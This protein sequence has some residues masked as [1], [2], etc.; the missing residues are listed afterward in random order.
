MTVWIPITDRYPEEDQVVLGWCHYTEEVFLYKFV[1]FYDSG[2][3]WWLQATDN[4]DW[5]NIK[6]FELDF[7]PTHWMPIIEAVPPLDESE[8]I[9][10]TL[11]HLSH[12]SIRPKVNEEIEIDVDIDVD[13]EILDEDTQPSET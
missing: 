13:V 9:L 4:N 10:D 12:K 2:N 3:P 11:Y 8:E 1:G 6:E 5:S 7:S